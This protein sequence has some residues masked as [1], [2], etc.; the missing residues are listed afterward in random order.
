LGEPQFPS[1][2][3]TPA[4]KFKE[5]KIKKACGTLVVN[6]ELESSHAKYYNIQPLL[7]NILLA[8]LLVFVETVPLAQILSLVAS[9]IIFAFY[10]YKKFA[11]SIPKKPEKLSLLKL[12]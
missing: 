11:L 9:N 1:L 2:C 8:A 4:H 7:R 12:S 6:P 10:I 5:D 3:T